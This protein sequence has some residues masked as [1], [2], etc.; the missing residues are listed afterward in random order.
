MYTSKWSLLKCISQFIFFL[1][2]KSIFFI[3]F[4]MIFSIQETRDFTN[5]DLTNMIRNITIRVRVI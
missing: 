5:S 2:I 3:L 4:I 1:N